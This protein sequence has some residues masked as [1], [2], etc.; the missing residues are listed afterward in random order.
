MS[1]A[2]TGGTMALAG[3]FMRQL[4]TGRPPMSKQRGALRLRYAAS[5][6]STGSSIIADSG[7]P[8]RAQASP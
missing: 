4:L 1:S 6:S 7:W 5:R 2:V 3:V 8:V